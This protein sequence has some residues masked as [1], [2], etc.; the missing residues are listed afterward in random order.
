MDLLG[1]WII[2]YG[3]L[4]IIYYGLFIMDYLSW[5][6]YRGLW[7]IFVQGIKV[8]ASSQVRR[9]RKVRVVLV[10]TNVHA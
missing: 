7:L 3:L 2:F 10:V 4:W 6:I 8:E 5:I 9:R 1:I